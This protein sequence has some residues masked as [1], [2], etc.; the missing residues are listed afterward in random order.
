M[1]LST[2][3][4]LFAILL[5]AW[6]GC[7]RSG[8]NSRP[9]FEQVVSIMV[10][11]VQGL[12]GGKALFLKKNGTTIV[13]VVTPPKTPYPEGGLTERRF[14]FALGMDEIAKAIDLLREHDFLGI[15]IKDHP[16]GVDE[17][18]PNIIVRFSTGEVKLVAKWAN[19]VHPQF[20]PIYWGLLRITDRTLSM[21]PI[22]TGRYDERWLPEGFTL[23]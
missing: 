11:D 23:Q 21:K 22:K 16:G 4:L 19:D 10:L 14:Q 20:D 15:K 18:R 6:A 8:E 9:R 7:S 1:L 17:A 12:G 3:K 13:Q 2:M 5:I